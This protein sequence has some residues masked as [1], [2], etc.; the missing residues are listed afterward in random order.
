MQVLGTYLYLQNI[1]C[2]AVLLFQTWAYDFW[3]IIEFRFLG[4][5]WAHEHIITDVE[6]MINI[7]TDKYKKVPYITWYH[8]MS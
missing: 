6:I 1:D 2:L 3:R 8:C 4:K 5:N 7:E